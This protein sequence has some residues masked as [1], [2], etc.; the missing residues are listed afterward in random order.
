MNDL[1][2][3][4][5]RASARLFPLALLAAAACGSTP[6]ALR[7]TVDAD[8]DV[9]PVAQLGLEFTFNGRTVAR[10]VP[11]V[12]S[13]PLAFPTSLTA[14]LPDGAGHLDVVVTGLDANAMI[15]GSGRAGV[16]ISDRALTD[17]TVRLSRGG[18]PVDGGSDGPVRDLAI[19]DGPPPD[20]A[21][22]QDGPPEDLSTGPTP[23]APAFDLAG[24]D[25]AFVP[26]LLTPCKPG[27][28]DCN[29]KPI[30]GCETQIALDPLHCGGCG[31][32]CAKGNIP[33][34]TCGNGVC[35][36]VCAG[37]FADCNNDKATD[38]C[39]VNIFADTNHC[40]ACA[41]KCNMVC[42]SGVCGGLMC[43]A[44]LADCDKMPQNGC[45]VTLNTDIKSCG[46]CARA[47]SASSVPTPLC[48]GGLCTGNCAATFADCDN[49]KQVN[50]CEVNLNSDG[51]NCGSCGNKCGPVSNGTAACMAAKCVLTGCAP[52]Y[53]DCDMS[54]ANGCEV[55]SSS[56]P[57]NCGGCG[58]V[59]GAVANGTPGCAAKV[60]GI[61]ACNAPF[62][63]CNKSG[64]DGCE[65]NGDADANNCNLCGKKCVVANGAPACGPSG[66]KVASCSGGFADCNMAAGDGCEVNI[67]VD[68][69][70]CGGCGKKCSMN[71]ATPA[72]GISTCIST[73]TMGFA[74]C[75]MDKLGDGCETV[76]A[77]NADHCG[78]CGKRCS[79]ANMASRTCG[80]GACNGQCS[81]GFAD[82]NMD[83]L[84]DGCETDVDKDPLNCGTC[85][86]AC[87][88][89]PNASSTCVAKACGYACKAGFGDCNNVVGDGCEATLTKDPLNCGK[90]GT[91]CL[92]ACI[93]SQCAK[94]VFISSALYTGN[95]GGLGGAD[96]KCQGLAVGKAL[97]GTWKAW[98]SDRMTSAGARLS[99]FNG[100][101]A[102][103]DGALVAADWAQFASANH[104]APINLTEA[105]TPPSVGV[106][107]CEPSKPAV[108]TATK[109]DGSLRDMFTTCADW[110]SSSGNLAGAW[111][112]AMAT[113]FEWSHWCSGGSCSSTASLY[114]I[115]Q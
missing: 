108:W 66:C 86:T 38:G 63:D 71:N 98:L 36:G 41:A 19:T 115:E 100:P 46:A 84:G 51:N 25:L 113:N 93:N 95:L 17:L 58:K 72:C 50:G 18:P 55:D 35:T 44:G 94:R 57:K 21:V 3:K 102:L 103:L 24:R 62:L 48:S 60:C 16:D 33:T 80:A 89:R 4:S 49:N 54:L 40:G 114:C 7:L 1:R 88:N 105:K 28:A 14:T 32:V 64:A 13:T 59:C 77:T 70:N 75:N 79:N 110:T 27:F 42:N 96:M 90:C 78:G 101:Y 74:D 87:P 83:K 47:C 31:K 82:C 20:L 112:A 5:V 76:P 9:G 99:H 69:A 37:G 104:L 56:D 52:G 85:G 92:G 67:A 30:D 81:A 26:D 10:P 109:D 65:V 106:G 111:G 12:A 29:G 2:M 97:G 43:N 107:G 6:T 61:A 22:A 45:E 68:T 23:D 53:F 73:C 8:P 39:E 11:A 15:L 91:P 34:P